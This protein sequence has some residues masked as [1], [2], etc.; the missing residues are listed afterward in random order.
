M[1]V[2]LSI[3]QDLGFGPVPSPSP[4]TKPVSGG[5]TQ[6]ANIKKQ[7]AQQK[8]CQQER[9]WHLARDISLENTW[10]WRAVKPP[11]PKIHREIRSAAHGRSKQKIFSQYAPVALKQ[12]QN[13]EGIHQINMSAE[14]YFFHWWKNSQCRWGPWLSK[15]LI[16]EAAD[17][18]RASYKDG[19]WL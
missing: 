11:S 17:L 14:P 18:K 19:L 12:A 13:R 10:G 4:E 5:K 8:V 1:S 6:Y 16:Q 15:S 3:H 7:K 2:P 9:V